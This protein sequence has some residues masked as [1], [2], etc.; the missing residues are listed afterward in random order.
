MPWP[1]FEANIR[2]FIKTILV[3]DAMANTKIVIITPPP[4]GRPAPKANSALS[5]DEIEKAIDFAKDLPSYK[6]YMSKKRYADGLLKLAAE[7]E[8]TGRVAG[9]NFWQ[10]IVDAVVNE[11]GGDYDEEKPPGCGL[12]GSQGFGP[13]WFTDGLHLDTK[14]YNVLSNSLFTLIT[15]KWPE[16]APERL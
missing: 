7:Y 15:E 4:I 8:Q 3:Q 14:G 16:L 9:L 13:G 2:A 11:A 5:A 1:T 6:T 12:Y 10:G